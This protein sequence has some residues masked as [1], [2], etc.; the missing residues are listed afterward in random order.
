M[1]TAAYIEF[2][3]VFR[4]SDS[5]G[6]QQLTMEVGGKTESIMKRT[7]LVANTSN[8]PVAAREASIYTGNNQSKITNHKMRNYKNTPATTKTTCQYI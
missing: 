1:T 2:D 6:V 3:W 7:A 8:M 5:F 4:M